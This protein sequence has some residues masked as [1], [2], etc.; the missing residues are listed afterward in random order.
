LSQA[1]LPI[2]AELR[3]LGSGP[4]GDLGRKEGLAYLTEYFLGRHLH[5]VMAFFKE[6]RVLDKNVFLGIFSSPLCAPSHSL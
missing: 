5:L 1:S 6:T 2:P 4:R 3:F